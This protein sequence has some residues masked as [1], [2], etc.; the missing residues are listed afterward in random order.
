MRQLKTLGEDIE[1][2]ALVLMVKKTPPQALIEMAGRKSSDDAWTMTEL[3]NALDRFIAIREESSF[4][5][6]ES[7]RDRNRAIPFQQD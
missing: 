4:F 3:T 7:V 6:S 1:Q 5:E 2:S